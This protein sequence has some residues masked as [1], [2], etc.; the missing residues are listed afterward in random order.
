MENY[1][2]TGGVLPSGLLSGNDSH[3][4]MAGFNKTYKNYPLRLGVITQIYAISDPH[5]FSKLATEYDVS[6]FEQNEDRGNTILVY[7]NCI[8]T[9]PL[10]SIADF[11]DKNLRSQTQN[12]NPLGTLNTSNQNGATVI[13]LCL[14]GVSEKAVIIGGLPH[15]DRESTLLNSN[16]YLQGEYNGINVVV[17]TDGSTALTFNGATDNDGKVINSSQKATSAQIQKDGS[18]V[19]LTASGTMFNMNTDGSIQALTSNGNT[20]YLNNTANE[21]SINQKDGS[22]VGLNSTG[23]TISDASGKQILTINDSTIQLTSGG[24]VLEQSTNHTISSGAVDISG[25]GGVKLKDQLGGEISIKNGMIAIGNPTAELLDL[26]NQ[27]LTAI[28]SLTVPTIVGPS[29]PPIN[30]AAF[31]AIQTQLAL[32][33]GS[34][35]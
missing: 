24:S 28:E 21:I 31:T 6:V 7:K 26:F 2:E 11:L 9:D 35:S 17:N 32:I 14:D 1:L 15:P 12:D 29:G 34:L 16:P 22:I 10:G 5:N 8:C 30:I 27:T 23:V 13:L 33:K 4:K 3:S 25:L 18:F 20:V 19:F